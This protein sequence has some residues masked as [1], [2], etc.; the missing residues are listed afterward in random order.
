M[1]AALKVAVEV[2][3]LTDLD[4]RGAGAQVGFRENPFEPQEDD[5]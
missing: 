5:P 4:V 2:G 3:H 1:P